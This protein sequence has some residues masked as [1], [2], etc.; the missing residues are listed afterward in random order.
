MANNYSV[1][2]EDAFLS[3]QKVLWN[4]VVR[5]RQRR[6]KNTSAGRKGFIRL[7]HRTRKISGQRGPAAR[8]RH[9]H[10]SSFSLLEVVG[11]EQVDYHLSPLSFSITCE[12]W[13]NPLFYRLVLR[14]QWDHICKRL[15]MMPACSVCSRN[16]S[17]GLRVRSFQQITTALRG[18][19]I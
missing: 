15:S 18:I 10:K 4:S 1:K 19:P 3:L 11:F 16:D 8:N 13:L 5:V 7:G 12:Y 6:E 2:G 17:A 14:T 9:E